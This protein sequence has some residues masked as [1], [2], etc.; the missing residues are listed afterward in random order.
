MR[1]SIWSFLRFLGHQ[2]KALNKSA[3]DIISLLQPVGIQMPLL[4]KKHIREC[5]TNAS[6]PAILAFH[7]EQRPQS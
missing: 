7:T 4:G 5:K 3:C 6:K 2:V 1:R